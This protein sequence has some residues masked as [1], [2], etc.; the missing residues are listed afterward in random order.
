M[1]KWVEDAPPCV[2]VDPSKEP[3]ARIERPE[4]IKRMWGVSIV[5]LALLVLADLLVHHHAPH[6]GIETSFGFS[7]WYGFVTCFL[8]V[9]V[10][11]KLV[12]LF[13]SRRDSYYDD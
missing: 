5:V 7:A 3:T 11:K 6:F 9:V 4:S 13:L 8:M 2:K 10:S 1:S 12:G